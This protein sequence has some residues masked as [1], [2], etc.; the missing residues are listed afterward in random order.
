MFRN[1]CTQMAEILESIHIQKR[2]SHIN[3][4]IDL[5]FHMQYAKAKTVYAYQQ[6][7]ISNTMQ[8]FMCVGMYFIL[9][10]TDRHMATELEYM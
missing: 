10:F 6:I 5:T 8:V 4:G 7:S 1:E 2:F 9:I 3:L